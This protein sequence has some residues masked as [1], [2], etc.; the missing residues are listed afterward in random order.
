MQPAL[1]RAGCGIGG[2]GGGECRAGQG[3]DASESNCAASGQG[4]ETIMPIHQYHHIIY[5][6]RREISNLNLK[7]EI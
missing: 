6:H 5:R 2:D 3:K 4:A 1:D 7:F